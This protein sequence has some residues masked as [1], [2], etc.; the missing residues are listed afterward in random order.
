MHKI[1]KPFAQL[2]HRRWVL[3]W[4]YLTRRSLIISVW[5]C[6]ISD[7]NLRLGISHVSVKF[8]WQ[9]DRNK[10]ATLP[11]VYLQLAVGVRRNI[12]LA[13]CSSYISAHKFT[14]TYTVGH[15]KVQ[16]W[17]HH[18][19]WLWYG[20]LKAFSVRTEPGGFK[21]NKGEPA[22]FDMVFDLTHRKCWKWS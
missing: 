3:R 2:T 5:V 9:C 15:V 11:N 6:M 14:F 13:A 12:C 7:F 8:C 4:V 20:S 17:P 16:F 10:L 18:F 21:C 19:Q 22:M 1:S